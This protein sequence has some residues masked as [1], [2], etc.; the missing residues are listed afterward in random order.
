MPRSR[1]NDLCRKAIH[2]LPLRF[3]SGLGSSLER[4]VRGAG[5]RR[6]CRAGTPIEA[7]EAR[8]L[9][10][11]V[12]S[13]FGVDA[14]VPQAG[15][16][17]TPTT[18]PSSASLPTPGQFA[19]TPAAAVSQPAFK[20]IPAPGSLTARQTLDNGLAGLTKASVL[21]SATASS[22][23]SFQTS[24]IV[25][26][27]AGS[28]NP[29]ASPTPNGQGYTPAQIQSAYGFNAI[30]LPSGQTFDDAG[31]GQTIAIVEVGWDPAIFSDIVQ[32]DTSFGIGGA[33]HDVTDTSFLTVVN[34]TGG[35]TITTNTYGSVE[36][37]LDVEWAHAMAPGA[38]ILV[39][40]ADSDL[41]AAV[42]YA[43]HQ[44]DVSVISISYGYNTEDPSE[45]SLDSLFTTPAGHTVGGIPGGITYVASSGDTGAPPGYPSTSPNVLSAG[46]TTLPADGSGNPNRSQEYGW[47]GSGGGISLY[48]AQPSYQMGV[49]TQSTS[50][51]TSPDL[52]FNSDPYTGFPICD[53]YDFGSATPWIQIGGT[54]AAAPILSSVI[55]IADELRMANGKPTLDGASQVLP[56]LYKIANPS[57]SSY[58]PNAIR[59]ITT[60]NN[61]Y[62]A[63]VGYDLVTGLGTPNVQYLIPDLAQQVQTSFMVTNTLGD[64]SAGSLHWAVTQ[65]N[66]VAGAATIS[67][68]PTL[69]STPQTITLTGSQL[70]LSNTTGVETILA[71]AAPLTISGGGLSRVF[72]IDQ[73]V[74]ASLSGLIITAGWAGS[75]GGILDLGNLTLNSSTISNSIAG[76]N[77]G[78]LFVGNGTSSATLTDCIIS[79]NASH[80]GYGGGGIYSQGT[81]VLTDCTINANTAQRGGGGIYIGLQQTT[82][83]NVTI[84]GNS[85]GWGGGVNDYAGAALL[86]NVTISGNSAS[87][88]SGGFYGIFGSATLANTIVAGNTSGGAASD[89]SRYYT[90]ISGSNNL[91]GTGGSG[92]MV[93]GVDGN[94][95][96]IANPLLAPL[97]YYGGPLK[98]MPLLSG[99]PAINAGTSTGAPATDER[100]FARVDGAIDIGAFEATP[101]VVNSTTDA[102]ITG[103]GQLNLRQA[104]NLANLSPGADTITFD[105]SV[106]AAP[107]TITLTGGQL[108]LSD[109]VTIQGPATGQVTISGNAA[110]RVFQIDGGTTVNLSELTITAGS[111]S[112]GGGIA[113]FGNLTL[114]NSMI[115]NSTASGNGGGLYVSS[116]G[117]AT[118]TGCTVS[119]NVAHDGGGIDNDHGTLSL[120]NTTVA[121]N[122]VSS[123][124]P[125]LGFK[126]AVGYDNINPGYLPPDTNAAVGGATGN[127]IV[128]TVNV[129]FIVFDKTTGSRLLSESLNTLFAPSGHQSA[130]DAYVVWDPLVNRW[131][132]D[133]INADDNSSLLLA[134]SNDDNPLHGFS[135]QFV[136]PSAAPG[137]LADF[138]KFG[139]NADS[140]TISANEF[141]SAS[142]QSVVTV[143]N[144]ADALAGILTE[145]QLAPSFNFRALVPAQQATALPGD[146]IWFVAAP[147]LD[148]GV[149]SN[150]LRV[151]KLTDPFGAGSFIDYAVTVN[152]Y[153]GYSGNVNQPGGNGSVAANDNTV[154]QVFDY[155]GTLVLAFPGSTSADGYVMPKVQYYTI[156]VSSGSPN[157]TRQG[158]VDP[159]AGV[160]AFFP[161]ASINPSTGDIGL[162]W[163]QSSSTEYVSMYVGFVS[164]ATGS[165]STYAAAPGTAYEVYSFRNGDYSTVVYDPTSNSFW[166]ANEYAG[167]DNSSVLWDTWIQQFFAPST[168]SSGGGIASF[169]GVTS[170][171]NC[172]VTGNNAA[173]GGGIYADG[174]ANVTVTNTIVAGNSS[175]I[176]GPVSGSYNLIGTGGSG[177]LTDGVN[178]NQVGV[179]NPGLSSLGDFG[180]PTLTMVLLP[181]SPGIDAGTSTG[182]PAT[183]QRG[184]SRIGQ[185]DIG[186]FEAGL[187]LVVNTIAGGNGASTGLL[188]LRQ[189]VNLANLLPGENAIQFDSTLFTT[190]WQITLT[191]GEIAFTDS[192][193]TTIVAPAAGLTVSGN[194]TDR[195]FE[196]KNFAAADLSGLTIISGTAGI[197]G[198]VLTRYGSTLALTDCTLS[199]N[200]STSRFG[201]G[202]IYS[203]GVLAMNGCTVVGNSS[204]YS[205]GGVYVNYGSTTLNHCIISGNSARGYGGGL[206]VYFGQVSVTDSSITDNTA[207]TGG[208]VANLFG[209]LSIDGTTLTGNVASEGG[210]AFLER[211]ATITNC[212]ISEN[213]AQYGGGVYEIYGSLAISNTNIDN[214]TATQAGGGV[215][216]HYASL[217]MTGG[218]VSGNDAVNYGGGLYTNSTNST[219]SNVTV[220]GNTA[221]YWGGGILNLFG[222]FD[223]SDS[224]IDSNTVYYGQG[225]GVANYYNSQMTLSGDDITSN[226]GYNGGGILN[227]G[228]LSIA[229]GTIQGNSGNFGGGLFN[230]GSATMT[231]AT[232]TGNQASTG[233]GIYTLSNYYNRSSYLSMTNV[234]VADNFSS[235]IGGGI[236]AINSSMSMDN[237]TVSGNISGNGGGLYI[238]DSQV[239]MTDCSVSGNTALNLGGGGVYSVSSN[240]NLSQVSM[241]DNTGN[242]SGGGMFTRNT[243]VNMNGGAISGNAAGYFGG[244]IYGVLGNVS[245]SNVTVTANSSK[246]YGG[247]IIDVFSNFDIQDSTISNN[248][249]SYYGNGLGGGIA[250][251]SGEL[252]LS[253][254]VIS[255]NHAGNSGGGVW[256]SGVAQMTGGSVSGN[257]SGNRGGGISASGTM[258]LTNLTLSNN[259]AAFEG[260]GL[261]QT[262]SGTA[263]LRDCTVSG[264]ASHG[265]YGGGGVYSQGVISLTNSTLNAN[266]AQNAGGGIYTGYGQATLTNVT[267][268]GNASN[269]GGGGV[270]NFVAATVLT[271]TIVANNSSDIGGFYT[272]SGS[273][274]LI[275]TGGSGG[276]VNGV[277]ENLV[278]VSNVLLAPLG[279]YGGSTQTMPL[280]PGSPAINAGTS[281]GAPATDQRGSPRVG[282]V[283]IGAFESSGFTV[284]MTSGNGQQALINNAFA[285]P[286]VGTVTANNPLE[287]VAGGQV[288]FSGPAS[289]AGA[290]FS[291]PVATIAAN[292]KASTNVTANAIGGTY[293][294]SL[295]GAGI[296]S[297]INFSLTN[298]L[299][300]KSQVNNT[301]SVSAAYLISG[302]VTAS[303]IGNNAPGVASVAV[304]VAVDSNPFSS[305]PL[306]VLTSGQTSFTYQGTPGHH[307]YF[308]SIAMDNAANVETKTTI[309]ASTFIAVPPPITSV[310]TAT[311]NTS[312]ATIT[313][314]VNGT[315]PYGSGLASFAVYVSVNGGS[316]QLV[317]TVAAGTPDGSGVSHATLT[318]QGIA[319]GI[320]KTYAFYSVGTDQSGRVE[321]AHTAA[322]VTLTQT[323][324]ATPLAYTGLTIQRGGAERSFIRYISLN[325][326]KGGSDLLA[327]YANIVANPSSYLQLVQ[328]AVGSATNKGISLAGITFSLVGNSIELNFGVNGL[329]GVA[330]GSS[331]LANYW[332]SL[333][334]GDG[335]YK[336]SLDTTGSGNFS[337]APSGS[338]A[339]LLGDTNGDGKVDATD[340]NVVNAPQGSSTNPNAD[341]NGDGVCDSTDKYLVG[342]SNGR[343][344]GTNPF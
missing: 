200:T 169:G 337:S 63:G 33:A 266:T 318:Y 14:H 38:K 92:G 32:F 145:V 203:N 35:S 98:T 323:F 191:T 176:I 152:T 263:T 52:S 197:G 192:A 93:N 41:W 280:L 182:A 286:L 208:G 343:S 313:L 275:G 76:S 216:T 103:W 258:T 321:A 232:V 175:D 13:D 44:P 62:S 138:P 276:L 123:F 259:T 181:G 161:S 117:S 332:T 205:G 333:I 112:N 287:P 122:R 229:D 314:N 43:A 186:A 49:V 18:P 140:I 110:S 55:A 67:F 336:L 144:K 1:L 84:S 163:M 206:Q 109:S 328:R 34:E 341:L 132:V 327:L 283:D 73:S 234:T 23:S 85:A 244:G 177:G 16:H 187:P 64:Q 10:S 166:A 114:S 147:Y 77:G 225:G 24:Y 29:L 4:A 296:A 265:G 105:S 207:S 25:S 190:H 272:V 40:V 184:F 37:A 168:V 78:G 146:P 198:G 50:H 180:G 273:N 202:G 6:R 342:K 12:T 307:Y 116:T 158:V 329:G 241:T 262:F 151:T 322:D 47:S 231:G 305:T 193:T 27:Q 142:G 129:E 31:T 171:I 53:S 289:G 218:T 82:L 36:M 68:D 125:G 137:G 331:S 102:V 133:S 39:V 100:G 239:G 127:Y 124:S 301:L 150:S 153:G 243:T 96:G 83:T 91:I 99:S 338:F 253:D 235:Q 119:G 223:I 221:N 238:N 17:S 249:S 320:S 48:E 75:G 254:D 255:N 217:L 274:N 30:S 227:V 174:S 292:G 195:V 113:D 81:T 19:N 160:A 237:C 120:S 252:T 220:S 89:I 61:G 213:M 134:I 199:G 22:H 270:Q 210:G 228:T 315:D 56:T 281:T 330:R 250:N 222:N 340:V 7:L 324:A 319:D 194:H 88:V 21:A 51:R 312:N 141:Y 130:G 309:D 279:F 304:Y 211:G 212:H 226:V 230:S 185:V 74:S 79:G 26:T 178:G 300:L 277:D 298:T 45:L 260:W 11:A 157:L 196:V 173:N 95:V 293:N 288:T 65:A 72:Q 154:T 70:E 294:V 261:N 54:S 284:S 201:G 219:V 245:L 5:P 111:A 148:P 57:S 257:T 155:N 104:V 71:P 97:G 246:L 2:P 58:D 115:T 302:T 135:T 80:G 60:G 9:L 311:P 170:L 247:G 149:T 278:G 189:A 128:E 15:I 66:Q 269:W 285:A 20:D 248:T 106:F 8:M 86:T 179:A 290:S 121:N 344:V 101:L 295:G 209:F 291:N 143:V 59:D 3:L 303:E 28:T 126:G 306:V 297:P 139:Y 164:G 94:L 204:T 156:D 271:N 188:S 159:G 162:T 268:S 325:F 172:T 46:G 240:L 167:A 42:S 136:I 316:R 236:A 299:S 267:I 317:G 214:N 339:R 242:I 224:T 131:Y 107:Q 334:A 118:L 310:A 264:N 183:D 326:N 69:F 90:S 87:I 215:L 251:Y 282:A 233:G 108:E 165:L 308:R 256:N 335:W